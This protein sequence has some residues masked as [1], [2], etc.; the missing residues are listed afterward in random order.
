MLRALLH[1]VMPLAAR[2]ALYDFVLGLLVVRRDQGFKAGPIE[3]VTPGGLVLVT[4]FLNETLGIGRAAR[5]TANALER[6]GFLVERDDLRPSFH[7]LAPF[8]L[9]KPIA[10]TPSVWLIHA[11]APECEVAFLTRDFSNLKDTYRIGYW[12]WETSEVPERWL[13]PLDWFHEIW[14][15]THF[16]RDALLAT[17]IQKKLD[18]HPN[19]IRVMPHPLFAP[20]RVEK[21]EGP[22]KLRA[23][24]MFDARSAFARKNPF[25]AVK[26][27]VQAFPNGTDKAEL[28]IKVHKASTDT[29][30]FS[31]LHAAIA[32]RPEISILQRDYSDAEMEAF[33]ASIDIFLSLHRSEGFGL[34]LAEIMA[35]GKVTIATSWSGN[36]DF[37]RPD[38]SILVPYGLVPIADRS[39]TY[40]GGRWAEAD[41]EAAAQALRDLVQYPERIAVIGDKAKE[42]VAWSQKPWSRD[43]LKDHPV[44]GRWL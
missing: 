19:L 18:I 26:A 4:G 23:L 22:A 14:V 15:P 2:K 5:M 32:D 8:I 21:N 3:T 27:W 40:G 42:I 13:R 1:A 39:G 31:E 7:Y 20:I 9:R 24:C 12:A 11:N 33:L 44:L 34:G 25:G 17:I 38:N 41:I 37:M 16:V 10:A 30:A 6:A 35:C 28:I 36:M 29:L 43:A